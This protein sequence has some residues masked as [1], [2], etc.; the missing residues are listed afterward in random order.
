MVFGSQST[1]PRPGAAHSW[2]TVVSVAET[3]SGPLIEQRTI[4]WY[5][6]S[7]DIDPLMLRVE[8]GVNLNLYATLEEV[9]R[10]NER[11][12]VWGPF[13]TWHGFYRRFLT[14]KAFLESGAVGYQCIDTI[15]EAGRE[16]NALNCIHA[17]TD[18]DPQFNRSRYP[19]IFFGEAA[20]RNVVRQLH[21]RPVLIQPQVTH[22]WLIAALWLDRYPIYK[23]TYT[24]NSV[25]FSPAA[26]IEAAGPNR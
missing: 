8:P 3:C 6:R 5:P 2:A 19:L 22:D 9:L 16:G 20:S 17:L 12:S 26:V 18:M 25:E 4:S 15:G 11:V 13:E 23:R 7:L 10:H 24:G 21:D 14:Q 1:P